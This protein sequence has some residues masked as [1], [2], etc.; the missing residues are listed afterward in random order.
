VKDGLPDR[1][2]AL[3]P[4]NSLSSRFEGF[5]PMTAAYDDVDARLARRDDPNPV[6][7]LAGQNALPRR[8][9]VLDLGEDSLRH[10]RMYVVFERD[11]IATLF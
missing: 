4:I 8:D 9:L 11:H 6:Y 2:F 5:R 1:S 7:D 3:H 10:R